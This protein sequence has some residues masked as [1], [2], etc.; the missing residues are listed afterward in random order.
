VLPNATLLASSLLDAFRTEG[1][2]YF[3]RM[4]ADLA[5]ESGQRS[6]SA[7]QAEAPGVGAG[8]GAGAGASGPSGPRPTMGGGKWGGHGFIAPVPGLR[9]VVAQDSPLSTGPLGPL[10]PYRTRPVPMFKAR[11]GLGMSTVSV[12]SFSIPTPVA[13]ELVGAHWVHHTPAQPLLWLA[14]LPPSPPTP[15]ALAPPSLSVTAFWE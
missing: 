6:S 14:L 13:A 8:A 15:P 7:S 3:D 1:Q 4:R 11:V 9:E 10:A 12:D 5:R 2:R